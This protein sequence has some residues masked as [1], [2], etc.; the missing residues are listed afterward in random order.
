M[1]YDHHIIYIKGEDNTVVDALSR[2]PNTVDDL[3]PLPAAATLLVQTDPT[4]LQTILSSYKTDPFCTKLVACT[5]STLGVSLQDG[6]LYVSDHLV[7]PRI[8]SLC[9]DLFWLTHDNLGHFGFD[10]SYA[11]LRNAYYWPNMQRDLEE[12]YIP[13]CI[14]CQ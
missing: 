1:H 11:S 14:D 7:I 3:E 6:L 13:A 9:K 5:G 2:L 8:G 4:H 10:K 12:A